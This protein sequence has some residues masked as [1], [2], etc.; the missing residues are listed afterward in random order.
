MCAGMS[1]M[2]AVGSMGS[3]LCIEDQ[4]SLNLEIA[5][6]SI[7]TYLGDCCGGTYC[8]HFFEAAN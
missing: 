5:M 1:Q 7:Q 8:V 6:L 4:V 2:V 3:F